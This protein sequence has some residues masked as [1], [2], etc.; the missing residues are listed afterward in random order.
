VSDECEV[1]MSP[2]ISAEEVARAVEEEERRRR[3]AEANKDDAPQRALQDMMGGTLEAK[4]EVTLLREKLVKPPWMDAIP[5]A[6]YNAEQREYAA[7]RAAAALALEE[8]LERRKVELGAEVVRLAGEIRDTVCAFDER[9]GAL[10][11]HRAALA[12]HLAALD[13]YSTYL[14]S[15]LAT[16]GGW[17]DGEHH[18]RASEEAL[19]G[20]VE[21][22][23]ALYA[24][25]AGLCERGAGGVEEA[26]GSEKALEKAF[27]PAF[28]TYITEEL[29]LPQ[30]SN[31]TLKV[32]VALF[33]KRP[34]GGKAT[35]S[36]AV[37]PPATAS[38]SSS[39]EKARAEESAAA[40][41]LINA[42]LTQ[43]DLPEG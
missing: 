40:L 11:A 33:K 39:Q 10:G 8:V 7:E 15:C 20:E 25:H 17:K 38:H 42:P 13:L 27:R 21:A 29:L 5:E 24:A 34:G 12:T 43:A 35:L 19:R 23:G 18:L 30:P 26:L 1:G 6:K 41:E 14:S 37:A 9:L 2:Y 4:D 31:A 36:T 32:L 16:R 28:L 22:A 3:E